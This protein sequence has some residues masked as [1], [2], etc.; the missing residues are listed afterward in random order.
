MASFTPPHAQMGFIGFARFEFPGEKFVVRAT[1]SNIGLKQEITKPDVIEG[2][3]DRSVYQLGPKLVDGSVEYPAIMDRAGRTDPT[4]RLFR[5]AIGRE[6]SGPRVGRIKASNSFDVGVRY[7]SAN[8]EFRYKDCIVN[9]WKFSVQAGETVSISVD[10]IGRTREAATISAFTN[11]N[12]DQFPT[13]SRIVTWN[14]AVVECLSNGSGAP[15]ISG[16]YVRSFEANINN[17]AERYYTLNGELFPQDI[18]ARKRDLDGNIVLLGRHEQL[19]EYSLTNQERCFEDAQIKF[20][21]DLQ[22]DE[23]N[24]VFVATW[25]NVIYQIEEL[26]LTNELFETTVNWHC[27][28]D[29][30]DL[31]G[32]EFLQTGGVVS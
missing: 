10:L 13:Q 8:S 18:A 14:D 19:G 26:A 32:S 16:D 20:G 5:A 17:N 21:Y 9:T 25:P 27:V 28:P 2:R 6:L 22:R 29:S 7:S 31:E 1:S 4:A 15:S 23:C 24:S 30:P 3:Y 12:Q 11:I